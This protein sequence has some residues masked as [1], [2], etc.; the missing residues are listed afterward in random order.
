[1]KITKATLKQLIKE[2]LEEMHSPVDQINTAAQQEG[3]LNDMFMNIF[4]SLYDEGRE[5]E[6]VLELMEAAFNSFKTLANR[7]YR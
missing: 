6:E 7:F 2:E 1:M 3:Q 4:R 5:V